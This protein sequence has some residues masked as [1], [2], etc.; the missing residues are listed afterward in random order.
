MPPRLM[1]ELGPCCCCW[2]AGFN[3]DDEEAAADPAG[4]KDEAIDEEDDESELKDRI[5]AASGLAACRS[6]REQAQQWRQT[7]GF[8]A[9]AMVTPPARFVNFCPDPTST[10]LEVGDCGGELLGEAPQSPAMDDDSDDD[11]RFRL[12]SIGWI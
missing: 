12:R 11:W 9:A 1:V 3:D 10:P 2:A 5:F 8:V 4:C 6:Q 7:L